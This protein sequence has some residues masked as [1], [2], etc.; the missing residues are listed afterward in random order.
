MSVKRIIKSFLIV[1]ICIVFIPSALAASKCD[2]EYKAE[3]SKIAK[4]VNASYEIKTDD[5]GLNYFEFTVYNVVENLYVTISEN[6]SSYR[7]APANIFHTSVDENN[8][9]VFK[10][11]NTFDVV[12]YTFKVGL[13]NYDCND[14][15]RTFSITKPKYNEYSELE[16]CKFYGVEDLFYCQPWITSKISLTEAGVKQKIRQQRLQNLK[17]VTTVCLSCE[18]N[19]K[20]KAALERF[21]KIRKYLIIGLSIGIAADVALIIFLVVKIR[22]EII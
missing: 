5:K 15:L 6:G 10:I 21:N 3:M 7:E 2:Y 20:N 19:A 22:K 14:T 4:N 12:K 18:E 11:Y 13:L 17:D 8:N 1:I 16:E 9:Y